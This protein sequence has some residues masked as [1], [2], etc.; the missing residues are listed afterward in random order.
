MC[1][2]GGGAQEQRVGFFLKA[3][4]YTEAL[5]AAVAMKSEEALQE[6]LRFGERHGRRDIVK[7]VEEARA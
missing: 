1:V 6:I 3:G 2:G 5:E 4:K 7:M